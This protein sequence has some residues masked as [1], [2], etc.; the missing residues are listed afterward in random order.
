[1]NDLTCFNCNSLFD[2]NCQNVT[3]PNNS[4]SKLYSKCKGD[5][6]T[7][8]VS[9]KLLSKSTYRQNSIVTVINSNLAQ[10]KK[11]S[12]SMSSENSTT[13]VKMWS[14]E[15]NCT[16][17]CQEGCIV[18]G[19]RTKLYACTTCCNTNYCNVGNNALSYRMLSLRMLLLL[20]QM[21]IIFMTYSQNV[22]TR[23]KIRGFCAWESSEKHSWA[24]RRKENASFFF[25]DITLISNKFL[26][27]L[28]KT[29]DQIF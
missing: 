1:M 28:E 15:R 20:L 21:P 12:Y 27:S 8:L 6:R 19:E 4:S 5:K 10:V 29:L 26:K 22:Y 13:K 3:K 25:T 17:K 24:V 2:K 11:Y 9:I 7:C 23:V 14:L 18:I 16:N